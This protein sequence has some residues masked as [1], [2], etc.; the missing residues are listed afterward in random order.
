MAILVADFAALLHQMQN[1]FNADANHQYV[2]LNGQC[3]KLSQPL[4]CSVQSLHAPLSARVKAHCHDVHDD[5]RVHPALVSTGVCNPG[6]AKACILVAFLF[7]EA[8][9]CSL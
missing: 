6:K 7:P 4:L 3:S 1:G 5:F 8:C 2:K 9:T